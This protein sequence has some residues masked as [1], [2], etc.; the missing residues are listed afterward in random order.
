MPEMD[1]DIRPFSEYGHRKQKMA[2]R[3]ERQ[4]WRIAVLYAGLIAL[5]TI[6]CFAMA[7]I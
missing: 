3:R 4:R 7:S 5:G 6:F 1:V 2:F